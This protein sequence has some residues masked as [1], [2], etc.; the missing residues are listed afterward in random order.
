MIPKVG[1]YYKIDKQCIDFFMK[2][3]L[4]PDFVFKCENSFDGYSMLLVQGKKVAIDKQD[5][6]YL[7]ELPDFTEVKKG[8]YYRYWRT[9]GEKPS[10]YSY[11]IKGMLDNNWHKCE[12]S[13]EISQFAIIEN[14][15]VRFWFDPPMENFYDYYE[16]ISPEEYEKTDQYKKQ[17]EGMKKCMYKL[18]P[19]FDDFRQWITED[20]ILGEFKVEFAD[21]G[22]LKEIAGK[23]CTE[24]QDK[25][26]VKKRKF[27]L[28]EDS[29]SL[30]DLKNLI[31][32]KRE[33]ILKNYGLDFRELKIRNTFL[34]F[35]KKRK[36]IKLG[37]IK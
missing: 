24:K 4:S 34:P 37:G 10:S 23:P 35:I 8:Y 33:S 20:A 14:M 29:F 9:D 31:T 21:I 5:Y 3:N 28:L 25:L 30:D 16:E 26:Y 22:L 1:K 15:G 32:Y 11:Y 2:K 7:A 6:S 17:I 13:G 36:F 27:I 18:P 12:E 19:T